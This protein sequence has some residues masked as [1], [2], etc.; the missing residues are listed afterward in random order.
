MP[1]IDHIVPGHIHGG[2]VL[3]FSLGV[4]VKDTRQQLWEV[5]DPQRASHGTV[6]ARRFMPTVRKW[7]RPVVLR[8]ELVSSLG[9]RDDY[10]TLGLP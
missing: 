2:A 1:N 7:T 9:V 5:T 6:R 10:K 8:T 3:W 4:R